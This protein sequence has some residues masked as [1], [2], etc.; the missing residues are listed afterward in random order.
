[1]KIRK[2]RILPHHNGHNPASMRWSPWALCA[3]VMA[4]N[5]GGQPLVFHHP[6]NVL[7][8]KFC[9]EVDPW[10]DLSGPLP[11]DKPTWAESGCLDILG[12]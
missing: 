8:V 2:D 11:D 10:L 5:L 12:D 6:P 9:Q 1:M 3:P 4:V 7:F